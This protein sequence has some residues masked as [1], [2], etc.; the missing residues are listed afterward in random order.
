LSPFWRRRPVHEKLLAAGAVAGLHPPAVPGGPFRDLVGVHGVHRPREWDAV[1][2]VEAESLP[3]D[4]VSFV[5]LPD[6]TLIVEEDV[7]EGSLGPLADAV[8]AALEPPYSAHGVRKSE[9]VWAV[10]ARRVEV[11]E[12]PGAEG[13]EIELAVQ[14]GSRTLTVDGERAFGGVPSLERLAAARHEDYLAH[15]RRLDGDLYEI[16]VTPL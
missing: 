6:G 8:E 12:L 16:R 13:D 15:A 2:T 3:G 5:A 11:A 4:E 14:S 1:A 9:R 7:P 10:G